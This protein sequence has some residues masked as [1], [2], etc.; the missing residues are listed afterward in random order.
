[1]TK[2]TSLAFYVLIKNVLKHDLK[3]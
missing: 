3:D 1:V 2:I